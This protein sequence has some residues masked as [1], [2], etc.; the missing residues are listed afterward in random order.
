[1]ND[2]NKRYALGKVLSVGSSSEGN[3]YY[4]ELNRKGYPTPFK[5]L[6][7]CGFSYGE[8]SRRLMKH[9]VSINDINA[10]L[11]SHEHQDHSEAVSELVRLGKKVYAPND[12]FIRAGVKDKVNP[13]YILQ[14]RKYKFIG[15]RIK[16][17]PIPLEHKNPDGSLVT[18][19]GYII[20]FDCDYG[21]HSILYVIDTHM[22]EYNL[23]GFKF[24]TIFIEANNRAY[25][26]KN[27]MDNE[28]KKN[29]KS[30]KFYHYDR[31]L[32][33]HMLVENTVKTL[34]GSKRDNIA[35]F[36]LSETNNIYLTHMSANEQVS[37][38]NIKM[39]VVEA[40]RKH[41]KLRNKEIKG[42]SIEL[43]IVK[44]FTKH[45]SMM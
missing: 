4:V 34:L 1:M 26:I 45:G 44:I 38:N 40:L 10:I 13:K 7:D 22:V 2:T 16:I 28:E 31:V 27:A 29:G 9:N 32:H 41:N 33:S 30:F 43:P 5:L 36:D 18:N 6:I 24:N 12:V 14:E 11:V 37:P 8:L 23:S 21:V 19:F 20:Q 3:A 17:L 35:G 25:V 39:Y 15:D 42:R